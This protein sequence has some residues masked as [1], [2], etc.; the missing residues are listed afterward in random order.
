VQ[1]EIGVLRQ[2]LQQHGCKIRE[3][4]ALKRSLTEQQLVV[5]EAQDSLSHVEYDISEMPAAQLSPA[6]RGVLW[7]GVKPIR[8]ILSQEG[9]ELC[10]EQ[11]RLTQQIDE[12]WEAFNDVDRQLQEA[13]DSSDA[14]LLAARER[15]G[16]A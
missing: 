1:R 5:D 16:I 10:A 11:C 8:R 14:A 13:Q 7:Q 6:Q 4:L 15:M 9:N 3:L 12:L 2:Q